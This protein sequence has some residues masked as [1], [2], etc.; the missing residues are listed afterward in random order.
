MKKSK[1]SLPFPSE[2]QDK[3]AVAIVREASSMIDEI[4]KFIEDEVNGL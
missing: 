1:S 2:L 3:K 4:V